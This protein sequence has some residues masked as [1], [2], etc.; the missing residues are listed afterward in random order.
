MVLK[1]CP[2]VGKK[3]KSFY[4]VL[5]KMGLLDFLL[6]SNKTIVENKVKS[7]ISAVAKT[8]LSVKNSAWSQ[9][10]VMNNVNI[11]G[12][13]NINIP[14]IRQKNV[15]TVD[16]TQLAQTLSDDSVTA[17]MKETAQQ[18]AEALKKGFDIWPATTSTK[19]ISETF[20]SMT[21]DIKKE[22]LNSVSNYVKSTNNFNLQDSSGFISDAVIQENF[23]TSVVSQVTETTMKTAVIQSLIKDLSQK[24]KASTEGLD[25]ASLLNGL[26][27]YYLGLLVG[28][29]AVVGVGVYT[30]KK[31]ATEGP[32]VLQNPAT[33]AGIT[34]AALA[35]TVT[36]TAVGAI[37]ANS[38]FT[39]EAEKSKK[40]RNMAG[41]ASL[42]LL[43]ADIAFF[44][45]LMKEPSKV[46]IKITPTILTTE[47][48]SEGTEM[49]DISPTTLT[50]T[51]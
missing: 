3:Q 51:Y 22:V 15:V 40:T 18:Q 43:V 9:T 19:N 41:L 33:M 12:A 27:G 46:P 48:T 7:T 20:A 1:K 38:Q 39:E 16:T 35:G 8:S 24:G 6:P 29:A 25:L 26:A 5:S 34:T 36:A 30:V 14:A 50:P 31:I 49:V 45:W 32:E 17:A 11:V 44:W 4:L 47:S 37:G 2:F 23:V 42:G 21:T 13:H 28:T 10:V